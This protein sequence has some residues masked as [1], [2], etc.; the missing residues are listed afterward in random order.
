M[1]KPETDRLFGEGSVSAN[2]PT[3]VFLATRLEPLRRMQS[4]VIESIPTPSNRRRGD[5][6]YPHPE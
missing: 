5:G 6:G 1:R 3:P 4:K 2:H